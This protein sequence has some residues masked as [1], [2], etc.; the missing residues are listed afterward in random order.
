MPECP[1]PFLTK[2]LTKKGLKLFWLT[3]IPTVMTIVVF[4]INANNDFIPTE[5]P[6]KPQVQTSDI[7]GRAIISTVA[8]IK[9]KDSHS[10]PQ[11]FLQLHPLINRNLHYGL[12]LSH[13]SLCNAPIS[14]SKKPNVGLEA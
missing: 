11:Y 7:P 3:N 10:F 1:V 14:A 9:L 2:I 5:L 13:L 8:V 4:P 6:I 12:L